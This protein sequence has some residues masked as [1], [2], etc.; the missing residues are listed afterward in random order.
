MLRALGASRVRRKRTRNA[1]VRLYTK[2]AGTI[3]AHHLNQVWCVMLRVRCC[4]YGVNVRV[5]VSAEAF[6]V[7][8]RATIA[9]SSLLSTVTVRAD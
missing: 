2:R 8:G 3:V 5:C 6:E 4:S 7:L 1:Y 9:H